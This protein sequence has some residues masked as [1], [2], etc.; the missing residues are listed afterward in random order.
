M[1]TK[2]LLAPVYLIFAIA[3]LARS[4]TYQEELIADESKFYHYAENISNGFYLDAENPNIKEGPGY[5]LYLS[6][7]ATVDI[8]FYVVR[9]SNV[10]FLSIAAYYLFLSLRLFVTQKVAIIG[11]YLFALY[12]PILR[13]ANLMYAESL[14]LML[15]LGFAYHFIRYFQAVEKGRRHGIISALFLGYLTLTKIIFAYVVLGV[16]LCCLMLALSKKSRKS[17]KIAKISTIFLYALLILSPYVLH[18]FWVTGKFFY[19]GTHGG[20]VLYHRSTPYDNEFGNSFSR[21]KIVRG[22]GPRSRDGVNVNIDQLQKN[23]L[24]LFQEI[25]SMTWIEKDSVLSEVAIRNMMAHPKKYLSNTI[26]NVSRLLFHFP[27][28]YRIQNL[29]TLGYLIPN[30]FIVVLTLLG[31]YP[32]YMGRKLIP[33]ELVILALVGLVYMAGHTVLGGRGRFFIPVVPILIIF[34]SFVYSHLLEIRIRR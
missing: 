33:K 22:Q 27:F 31:L 18:N 13:W 8:P 10:L 19:L 28:S 15:L 29:E 7:A 2:F 4:S 25:D 21:D 6:I 26:A 9:T 16:L 3:I 24:A 12:P 5:P 34:F 11:T 32:V 14:A 30:M 17:F 23:H 20:L 1:N